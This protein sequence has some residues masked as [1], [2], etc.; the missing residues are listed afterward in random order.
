MPPSPALL[1]VSSISEEDDGGRSDLLWLLIAVRVCPERLMT[2][3]MLDDR[4]T[5]C[6]SIAHISA[7][8]GTMPLAPFSALGF[9]SL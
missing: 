8:D 4:L 1:R 7:A 3:P 9:V 5:I 6:C 2:V